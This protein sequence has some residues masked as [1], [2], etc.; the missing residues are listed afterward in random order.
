M[1]GNPQLIITRND[2]DT[3]GARSSLDIEAAPSTK[4]IPRSITDP[5][6][7]G[8]LESKQSH[9]IKAISGDDIDEIRSQHNDLYRTASTAQACALA[10]SCK[11]KHPRCADL[12]QETKSSSSS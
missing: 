10:K 12:Y 1:Q 8:F 7:E 11:I 4:D 9:F 2:I 3:H 6:A 5:K